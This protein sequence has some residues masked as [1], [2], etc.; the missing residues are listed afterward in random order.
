MENISISERARKNRWLVVQ[1]IAAAAG[2]VAASA[3]AAQWATLLGQTAHWPSYAQVLAQWPAPLAWLRWVIGDM[4]EATFYK[5]E[6]ASLGMLA[7]A[8][9]AWMAGRK[10]LR[11][12]GFAISYAT[13]LWPWIFFSS[14][15]GLLLSN[16]F[17]GWTITAM[18]GWQPTFVAF[19]S[20]PAAMVLM[21]GRG[22]KIAIVGAVLGALLV[23]PSSLLLVN[24]VITPLGLPGVIGNVGG[25]ALGSVLA[26]M[27]FRYLPW[28]KTHSGGTASAVV[29]NDTSH[30]FGPCWTLRRMLADFTES[31]FFGNEWASVGL[32]AGVLVATALN[33][34]APAYGSGLLAQIL[35]AQMLAAAIGVVIWR[36]QWIAKGW[37]PTY[38]PVVSV[39]PAAVLTYGGTPEVIIMGALL[40]AVVGPPLA[41]AFSRRLPG[42]FHPYVGNVLS[43]AFSTLLIV[44]LLGW[45]PGFGGH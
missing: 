36:H 44:P 3:I 4:S 41:A 32:I 7:G 25:M 13:G 9:L 23:T 45:L 40:G 31:P 33:V 22:W 19:V 24:F 21:Y 26:F 30:H 17:W 6:L 28:L 39:A 15:L 43:M 2:L 12:Q 34:S 29:D 38:I 1:N 14:T 16:L 11:W 42:D 10:G 27:L 20:L 37:Y 8:A 35:T 18:R 5:H